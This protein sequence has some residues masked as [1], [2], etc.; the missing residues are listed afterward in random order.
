MEKIIK[1]GDISVG[2]KST[3]ALPL[4]YKMQFQR[5]LFS[6]VMKIEKAIIIKKGQAVIDYENFDMDV[7]YNLAWTCAKTYDN[8]ILPPM[9]WFDSFEVFPINDVINEIYELI[10]NSLQTQKK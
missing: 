1:I 6:D 8:N 5:D 4:R 9:E 7:I 3:G 10:H 2:F